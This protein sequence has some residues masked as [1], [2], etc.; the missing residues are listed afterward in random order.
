MLRSVLLRSRKVLP[1][2]V[3][4]VS[5]LHTSRAACGEPTPK[6]SSTPGYKYVNPDEPGMSFTEITDRAAATIFWTE[7]FRGKSLLRDDRDVV[8]MKF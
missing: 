1:V 2:P 7:L 5:G 8:D 4:S 3:Y 6:Q